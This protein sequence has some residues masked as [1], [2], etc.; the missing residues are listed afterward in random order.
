MKPKVNPKFPTVLFLCYSI[1]Q[2]LLL[3][4]LGLFSLFLAINAVM[5]GKT[6]SPTVVFIGDASTVHRQNLPGE[7]WATVSICLLFGLIACVLGIRAPVG[8]ARAY[9]ERLARQK[10][11]S[12]DP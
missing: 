2:G 1:V 5:T 7:F 3:V 10:E 6:Y 12:V 8:T 11:N 9:V 4:S